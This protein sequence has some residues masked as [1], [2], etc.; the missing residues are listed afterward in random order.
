MS[1]DFPFHNSLV[2]V[3]V[4]R[5][6]TLSPRDALVVINE[7]NARGSRQLDPSNANDLELLSID[8]NADNTVSPLDALL[9]I[10]SL[11]D[12][13]GLDDIVGFRL[14]LQDAQGNPITNGR[15]RVGDEFRLQVYVQDLRANATGLFS[16]GMDINYSDPF[17]F[18]LNGTKP[19]DFTDL[20]QFRSFF[21]KSSVF[22]NNAN[23]VFPSAVNTDGDNVPNEFDE[24]GA[25]GGFTPTGPAELPFMYALLRADN[26]GEVTFSLNPAE[27]AETNLHGESASVDPS[28]I[29]FGFA[30]NV[31][32]IKPVNAE[33]DVYPVAP[34]VINE[35]GG[36]VNLNVLAN[37][38][39]ETGSTGTLA[40]Q[41]SGLTQPANGTVAV[42]GTA[43]RYTPNLNFFG[44]DTFTYTAV[45]GLGNSDTA[46]VTVTVTSVN[47]PPQAVGDTVTGILEESTANVI[48]VL[49]ND[50]GGP[51]NESQVL[52]IDPA[53]LTQPANGTVT[54]TSGNTR[55]EYT[56]NANFFGSDSFQYSVIDSEGLKSGLATVSI[57]VDNVNDPPTAQN[58]QAVGILEESAN[59]VINVLANDSPGPGENAVDALTITSVQGFS[60][61]GSATISGSSVLYTPAG[62]FFGTETFTYTIQDS[63]GLTATATVTVTVNNVNDPVEAID[64]EVFVDELTTDTPLDLLANDRPGPDNEIAVDNLT[65]T[66]V[67]VP[68]NGGTV[69][70]SADKKSVLYTPDPTKLGPYTETF[71]YTMTDGQFTDTATVTVNVEPVVRPRARDDRFTVAED[72]SVLESTNE[73]RVLDN[74]LFNAGANRSFFEIT[75]LP[76]HGTATVMVDSIRYQP[77]PDFF[78]TDTLEYTI[79]DDFVDENENPSVPSTATVTITVTPV[80]DDPT[81]SDDTFSGIL[82][83][84]ANNPLN[85]LANDTIEPDIDETLTITQVGS[86]AAGDDGQTAEGGSVTISGSQLLYTPA[87][88][89]FGTDTFTYTVS[90]GNG[91]F[92][93]ATVTVEVDNVND[94]PTANADLYDGIQEDSINNALNVLANDTIEPDVDETLTIVN[95][96]SNAAGNDGLSSEGGTV[97]IS[98]G[99]VLYTPKPD[100]FGTD[101]FT[102][103]ISD[104]NGGTAQATVTVEVDDVNDDPTAVDDLV[105]AL[106]DFPDQELEVLPN[107]TIAPDVN[108]VLTIIGLGPLNLPSIDT[109]HGTA[110]ISQDGTTIIYTPDLGFESGQTGPFD[111]FTYTISDGRGGTSTATVTVDVIDAVP[112]DISG[113]IYLDVNNNGIQDPQEIKLAGV[114]VTLTGT[115]VRGVPLNLTVKTDANGVFTFLNILPNAE[116]DTVGYSITAAT[117]KYLI[118]GIDSIVDASTDENYNPGTA[119]N[120]VF[121]GI[122]LGLWGTPRSESNY[123]FGERGL[124]SKYISLAQYL[125]S[126]KTGLAMATNMQGA[127]YW[128]TLL[129]GWEGVKSAHV[130]LAAD[131]TSAELTIVD[132]NG[133]THVKTIGYQK[134]HLAGD[135]TTGELMIYFNGSAADLGFDLSGDE[136]TANAE[137]EAEMYAADFAQE[138]DDVFARGDWA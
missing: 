24:L 3:D 101:T 104:G 29:D 32:I 34:N 83:D 131:L 115:N 109:P 21:V 41:A 46:T 84:S 11:N 117:P 108:E 50:N 119:Q 107:D 113:V 47:D 67:T 112:S 71:Q 70:I 126:T 57:T 125:S 102:Y 110:S 15:V 49:A 100:F 42:V 114:D 59:N 66:L 9:V 53:T 7:L 81:A 103:T 51:A 2:P 25:F 6:W 61:G 91:G 77:D 89:F 4:T 136:V 111:E 48:D 23:Y 5:D 40:L 69:V 1:A 82:E 30:V 10:N 134:Y 99:Q 135:H 122:D 56:P 64:D 68:N 76:T 65:I 97:A 92:D 127:D 80:N 79:D 72:S 60:Q 44:T 17:F 128:F 74:D 37:D 93:T 88:N 55:V 14:E 85:V 33:D 31:T 12:G 39:L 45:D 106:K 73:F 90:D 58:D 95:V 120:D 130:Q 36:P 118:D 138:A 86:N 124:S 129:Q 27:E 116:D 35:D 87:P 54:L 22:P 52:T 75:K 18:S 123:A 105:M 43:I 94:D 8:T 96:G 28:L 132:V 121:T 62:N 13:E 78:G 137:G 16:A 63:G 20:G 19:D 98:G 133:N 26:V 38:F